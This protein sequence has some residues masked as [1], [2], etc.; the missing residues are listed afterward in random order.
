MLN[1]YSFVIPGAISILLGIFALKF[2]E[3]KTKKKIR[4]KH[5]MMISSF[6]WLWAGL[7]GGFVFTLA[8]G[9]TPIDGVFESLP[10]LTGTGITIFMDVEHLPHSILFFRALE[11]WIGGLGVV[12]MVIGVLTKPGSVSSKLY[13]QKHVKSVLNQV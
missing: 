3:G 5:G 13:H 2:F 4:L 8:T 9:I 7:I 6:A 11:Q 12:V 1:Y 10:A